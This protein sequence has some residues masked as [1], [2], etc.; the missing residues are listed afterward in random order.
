MGNW[1]AG[2]TDWQMHRSMERQQRRGD[3]ARALLVGVVFGGAIYVVTKVFG[4]GIRVWWMFAI[5]AG[6][7]FYA[8]RRSISGRTFSQN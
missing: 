2:M 7:A 5:V 8:G 1:L 4:D 3:M 6:I